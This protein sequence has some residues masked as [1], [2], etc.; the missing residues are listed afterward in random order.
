MCIRDSGDG[1]PDRHKAELYDIQSDPGER[2]N[3]I[4]NAKYSQLV[5]SL[6]EQLQAL[7]KDTGIERDE[8]PLDQGIKSGLP[9]ESIR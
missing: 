1:S 9:D 8:M 5:E 6:N 4:D 7:M 3:L 2:R